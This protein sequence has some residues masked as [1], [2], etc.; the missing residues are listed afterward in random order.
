MVDDRTFVTPSPMAVRMK[1]DPARP[2]VQPF[3]VPHPRVEI[4]YR[5]KLG[6]CYLAN[7]WETLG[8]TKVENNR[9]LDPAIRR[10]SPSS[11]RRPKP[12]AA[13]TPSTSSA[14]RSARA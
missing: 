13:S 4:W 11:R 8:E 7:G 9:E 14:S 5:T 3:Y 2:E 1:A 12:T 6:S 10:T